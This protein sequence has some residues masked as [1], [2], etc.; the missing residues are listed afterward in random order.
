MRNTEYYDLLG[1]SQNA[2]ENA[3]KK[4]YR[5]LALKYH[6][7]KAPED[8]KEEY[9]AKFKE[10]SEA[11]NVLSDKEKKRM[12]DQFGK[13]AVNGNGGAGV[14][15]FD[16]FNDIFGGGG[17]DSSGFPPG[18]HVRMGGMGG[19]FGFHQANFV[20]KTRDTVIRLEVSLEDIYKGTSKDIKI[21][22][23]IE[24][25]N[26]EVNMNI[27][28]PSGCQNGIKM[29]KKGFG[30]KQSDSEPGDVVIVITHEDHKLFKLSDNHIIMEKDISFGS[31]LVGVKFSVKHLSGEIITFSTEGLI[32]DGD[33]RIIKGK[34]IPHMR[35]DK[36]GDFVVKFNVEKTFTLSSKDKKVL[37]QIFPV[38]NFTIDPK[39]KIY[40][41]I[42]SNNI[43]DDDD[44]RESGMQCA[45]Q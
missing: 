42:S 35:T 18:V 34:G 40:N 4:A 26:D 27:N 24:G 30:N 15:P 25:K 32:E 28:I 8:K 19:P 37:K 12:Y 45:Q 20:R 17:F 11:Y 21:K 5:K 41:A 7:D 33:L 43:D 1:V 29:V 3:I 9:E 13:D 36:M 2:D 6:P 16:I 14:N 10:I 44:D 39:G 23:N 22:R 31:S 38:D